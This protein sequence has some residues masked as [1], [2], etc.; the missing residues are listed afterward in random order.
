MKVHPFATF[1]LCLL[2]A[3]PAFADVQKIQDTNV[4]AQYEIW[5]GGLHLLDANLAIKLQKEH[6]DAR[7]HA[8]T[9]GM[10]DRFF[11][12]WDDVHSEGNIHPDLMET[13]LHVSTNSWLGKI[14][15]VSLVYDGK[16]GFLKRVV[17][18]TPAEENREEVAPELTKNTQD[19]IS[20]AMTLLQRF[21][22]GESCNQTLAVYDGKR[23]FNLKFVA[24]GSEDLPPNRYGIY[25]GPAMQCDMTIER[26]A[27]FWKTYQTNW[28]EDGDAKMRLSF[29]L[30][31]ILPG[32]PVIPVRART[33][34]DFGTV[35]IHLTG[36][37]VDGQNLVDSMV[38]PPIKP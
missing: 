13:L 38:L 31:P 36:G 18:P 16:G 8:N 9:R 3:A 23:R 25:H 4:N 32:G 37:T 19:L 35:F 15:S 30:A 27:G 7:L 22:Q 33:Y 29:W 12:W 1:L 11:P 20:A 6:Y 28:T 5:G 14:N 26:V 24:V 21:S 10:I 34:G 17:V 2:A